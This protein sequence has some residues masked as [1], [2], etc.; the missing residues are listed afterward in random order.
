MEWNELQT[1]W[2]TYKAMQSLDVISERQLDNIIEQELPT[3]S[4]QAKAPIFT[5][6]L[7]HTVLLLIC[8]SC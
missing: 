7:A 4:V 8:Q 1:A 2:Q 5:Y 6:L 3:R